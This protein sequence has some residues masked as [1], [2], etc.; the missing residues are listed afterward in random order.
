QTPPL[1]LTHTQRKEDLSTLALH[2]K[3]KPL[4][5]MVRHRKLWKYEIIVSARFKKELTLLFLQTGTHSDL[6]KKIKAR[7]LSLTSLT[8]N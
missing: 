3:R 6:F 7:H 1:R 2:R 8:D 4:F 5:T